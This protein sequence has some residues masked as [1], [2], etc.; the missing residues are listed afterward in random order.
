MNKFMKVLSILTIFLMTVVVFGGA[1]VTKTGSADGCGATWPLC[2][3]QLVNLTDVTLEK[4]IEVFHRLSTGLASIFVILLAV[5]SWKYVKDR[6]E[7]KIIVITSVVFLILQ[8]FMG[9]M[10]VV[11]GQNAIIM[12]LH[13]GISIISYASIVMLGLFIFEIDM[14]FDAKSVIMHKKVRYSIYYLIIFTYIAIYTGAL[15]RH[16]DASLALPSFMFEDGK[17]V[18][19]VTTPQIVQLIHRAAALIMAIWIAWLAW[20][21]FK[22]YSHSKV[23]RSCSALLVILIFVQILLGIASVDSN[24]NL[25][26]ALLHSLTITVIFAILSYLGLI[27]LRSG[28]RENNND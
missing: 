28:R 14:K 19:P 27:A 7:T 1:L 17:F 8:A 23:L 10:A 3:G 24:V 26:I 12:A 21:V 18:M 11:W 22:Y 6:K 15:V 25:V 16:M 2:E 4:L 5:L 13:F 9:A 20:H